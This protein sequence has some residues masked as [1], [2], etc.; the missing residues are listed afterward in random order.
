MNVNLL[1]SFV[2]V[3]AIGFAVLVY[4]ILTRPDPAHTVSWYMEHPTERAERLKVGADDPSRQWPDYRNA[5]D[6]E[7]KADANSYAA[8]ARS[9]WTH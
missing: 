5:W 2:L 8:A 1:Y 6:A 7:L 9:Q 3:A 4:G